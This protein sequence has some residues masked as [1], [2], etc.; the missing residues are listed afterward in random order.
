MLYN[1]NMSKKHKIAKVLIDSSAIALDTLFDYEIPEQWAAM[2]ALGSR[3]IVPIQKRMAVGVI[4]D[5]ADHSDFDNLRPIEKV[6]DVFP[7]LTETQYHLVEWMASNYFCNR[8]EVVRLCLPPGSRLEKENGLRININLDE[9]LSAL[10]EVLPRAIVE[11]VKP[12][13]RERESLSWTQTEWQKNLANILSFLN[14][15][16]T[17]VGLNRFS[18]LENHGF[19][20]S[21]LSYVDGLVLN[22]NRRLKPENG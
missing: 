19:Q 11:R 9:L 13:L 20:Q 4:W 1:E 7:L 12:I 2:A 21:R 18:C 3:V 22:R 14:I 10:D 6:V 8:A 15:C 5:F 17:D 16:Y